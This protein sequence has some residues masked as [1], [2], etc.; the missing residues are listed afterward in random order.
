MASNLGNRSSNSPL[1]MGQCI[2]KLGN[3]PGAAPAWPPPENWI[4]P[5]D[6][7]GGAI[8]LFNRPERFWL[9]AGGN[10]IART[11]GGWI[12]Y[13]Y[14]L[15]LVVNGSYGNDLNGINFYQKANSLE[16]HAGNGWWGTSIEGMFYC[17]ANTDYTVHFLSKSSTVSSYYYQHQVHY[18]MWGYT[19]GEGVY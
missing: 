15:R 11:D 8:G 1:P 6:G 18:N 14:Q 9:H 12:R 2:R 4:D 10:C 3:N 13:D 16:D 17:E 7:T 5:G 19:I